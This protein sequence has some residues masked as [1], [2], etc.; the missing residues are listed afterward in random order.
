MRRRLR[1]VREFVALSISCAGSLIVN[2]ALHVAIAL[3][4]AEE[5]VVDFLMGGAEDK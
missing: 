3:I 5:T 4:V 2:I 1:L